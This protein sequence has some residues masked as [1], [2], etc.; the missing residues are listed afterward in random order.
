MKHIQKYILKNVFKAISSEMT[1]QIRKRVNIFHWWRKLMEHNQL[2]AAFS[3]DTH[4][5]YILA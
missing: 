5:I 2:W 1:N 4:G 3:V